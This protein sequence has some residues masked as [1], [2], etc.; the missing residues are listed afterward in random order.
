M[1]AFYHILET[2]VTGRS[3]IQAALLLAFIV[4]SVSDFH[5]LSLAIAGFAVKDL[6]QVL[7]L[8]VSVS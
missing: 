2:L 1:L 4:N 5:Q 8:L 6:G 7:D 3:S